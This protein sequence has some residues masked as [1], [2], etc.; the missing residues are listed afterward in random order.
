MSAM[1]SL[2]PPPPQPVWLRWTLVGTTAVVTGAAL[3]A[4]APTA[5]EQ[6]VGVLGWALAPALL[7]TLLVGRRLPVGALILA[8][9]LVFGYYS[10]GRPV[11]GMELLL[12][13]FLVNAAER[14]RLRAGA[15]VAAFVLVGEYAIRILVTGQDPRIL[16]VQF[17]TTTV[18]LVGALACGAAARLHRAWQVENARALRAELESKEAELAAHL[19]EERRRI[20]RDIHDV[21]GHTLVVV[22]QQAAIADATVDTNPARAREA[23]GL[24]GRTVREARQEVRD[25]VDLLRSGDAQPLTPAAGLG[26]LPDLVAAGAAD[27]LTVRLYLEDLPDL[28]TA[29]DTTA[30]RIIQEALTNVRRHAEATAV[31]VRAVQGPAQLEL[32]IQDDGHPAGPLVEGNGIRGMRERAAL[33]GGSLSVDA[34]PT[35]VR[36]H[37]LVPTAPHRRRATESERS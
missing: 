28:G 18:V 34:G 17:V 27:G 13:P 37:A 20:A 32:T 14:D 15:V 11:I 4:A 29:V 21:L 8:A 35:G 9:L 12:A 24:V 1:P 10:S 23:L 2:S 19:D 7:V 16:G 3:A 30:Y 26:Q 31:D 5:Q 22:G 6:P 33:L 36:V 25:S